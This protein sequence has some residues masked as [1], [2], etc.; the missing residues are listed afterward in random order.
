MIKIEKFRADDGSEFDTEK[1]C[2]DYEA[3]LNWNQHHLNKIFNEKEVKF[4]DI[5]GWGISTF[6]IGAQKSLEKNKKDEQKKQIQSIIG[7]E[8][9]F[10]EDLKTMKQ[11]DLR[12]LLNTLNDNQEFEKSRIVFEEMESRKKK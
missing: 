11:K 8:A 3:L 7:K 6:I 2:Q 4:Q 1:A 5:V 12:V 10:K 9:S